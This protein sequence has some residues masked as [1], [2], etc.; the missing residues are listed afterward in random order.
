MFNNLKLQKYVK[1]K[2][3]KTKQIQIHKIQNIEIGNTN[4]NKKM[5][6]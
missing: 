4:V 3:N 1:Y 6:N 2:Y 5:I